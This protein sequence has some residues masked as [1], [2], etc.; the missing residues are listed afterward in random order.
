[1]KD[2]IAIAN[3]YIRDVLSGAIPA[4]RW[5]KLACERQRNDLERWK[6]D[7]APY[8]FDEREAVRPCR[9]IEALTH[10]KGELAGQKI[11]LEPWQIFIL[12]AVFGWRRK[13]GNRR[14]RRVYIEVPRGNGKSCLSSGV[15]LF[16]LCAD[17]EPG[18]EVYSFA[19]TRDQ[20]KIVFGDAKEMARANTD[21]RKAY[22]LEVLANALYIPST[23]STFQA[24]SSEG[25]TLDG[26][27]THCAI[28][29]ELHAHKRRDVYD[30]VETS[31][32]KR[33]NS[34][35]WC[36]TTAGTNRAGICYEVRGLVT[37]VL[38]G[39]VED[40]SQ[41]GVIYGLDDEDDWKTEAAL[42]KANPNWG[43]SVR[44]EV[45][46]S[47]QQ[48]AIAVPSAESNFRTKH[49]DQWMNADSGWMDMKAWAKCA[50]ELLTLADF[51][52]N[53]C[54]LG[55]DLAS[56]VDI[57]AKVRCFPR[58]VDG[59]THY[60]FFGD[61]WLPRSAVENGTNSQYQ[62]WEYENRLH[63]SDGPVTDFGAIRDSILEDCK[64]F[65][66]EEVPYDPFQATQLA[67][68]LEQENVPMLEYRQT[69]ANLS[70]PMKQ[71]QALVLEGRIHFDGD[72]VLTWMVSNVVCH[73]DSKDNIYPRK[74]YPENK[75]DG[76]VA[77]IMALARAIANEG[78]SF[79]LNA[80]LDM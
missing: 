80:F 2:F 57:A 77:G 42:E 73:V 62:G 35:M 27:N 10:V 29:D 33:A 32:G 66:V 60:Y 54:Y 37:K 23:A 70:E 63:V 3:G 47:L 76:V 30:V 4:C 7:F 28:V 72:P 49:L 9:F 13:E 5:V 46:R 71:F 8:R 36:I 40:P 14:F 18:A 20:A 79:D 48:K 74:E 34:L 6:D 15:A 39:A 64:R 45:I 12:T 26:L 17:H 75:I 43:V 52:G 67:G 78:G 38:N 22:G 31:T 44:P 41:F 11:K 50:D 21:L 24:K 68:E 53:E 59:V 56:K 1:M 51:E 61:Y 65:D 69:V 55:L 58:K 25:S 16:C 19:T